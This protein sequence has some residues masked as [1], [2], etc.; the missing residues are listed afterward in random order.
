METRRG[1]GRATSFHA[2]RHEAI[3]HDVLELVLTHTKRGFLRLLLQRLCED[4]SSFERQCSVAKVEGESNTFCSR[5][6]Y[7]L[8]NSNLN[9][10]GFH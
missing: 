2:D 6:E 5:K 4:R 9:G 10:R 7:S 1:V 8:E 3:I